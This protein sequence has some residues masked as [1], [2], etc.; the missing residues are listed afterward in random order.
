M[1]AP[2]FA[3]SAPQP[4]LASDPPLTLPTRPSRL[5]SIAPAIPVPH[6]RASPPPLRL[7]SAASVCTCSH[8]ARTPRSPQPSLVVIVEQGLVIGVVVVTSVLLVPCTSRF[9][10]VVVIVVI[11]V[12]GVGVL[13]SQRLGFF[14]LTCLA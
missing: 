12:F 6:S 13:S 1:S 9:S 5:P 10:V 8:V 14:M 7:P 4:C 3:R 11:I 2:D